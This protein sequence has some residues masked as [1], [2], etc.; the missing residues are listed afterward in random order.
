MFAYNNIG[1]NRGLT[2]CTFC[3]AEDGIRDGRVTGVQTCALPIWSAGTGRRSNVLNVRR[4]RMDW[5]T[6]GVAARLIKGD[7]GSRAFTDS[8]AR[9]RRPAH[10]ATACGLPLASMR[11]TERIARR[12]KSVKQGR[13]PS[14]GTICGTI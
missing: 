12:V 13:C 14:R 3:Q 2:L 8:R 5:R 11:G 6:S 7:E 4:V 10:Y 9:D 1:S